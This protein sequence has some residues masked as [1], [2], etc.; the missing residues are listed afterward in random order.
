MENQDGEDGKREGGKS[1]P[2]SHERR[3]INKGMLRKMVSE[4]QPN[5]P[6]IYLSRSSS[7]NGTAACKIPT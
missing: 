6:G 2:P 1:K 7:T 3:L 5:M 4:D